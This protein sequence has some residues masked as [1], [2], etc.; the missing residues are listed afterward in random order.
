MERLQLPESPKLA[1]VARKTRLLF[2]RQ[3]DSP[4]AL[5]LLSPFLS[6]S[7]CLSLWSFD[8][9]ATEHPADAASLW[10]IVNQLGQHLRTRPNLPSLMMYSSLP[11]TLPT[12]PTNLSI[13]SPQHM[14]SSSEWHRVWNLSSNAPSTMHKDSLSFCSGVHMGTPKGM[15]PLKPSWL[16]SPTIFCW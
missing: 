11:A 12:F 3:T 10:A 7:L 9:L 1:I 4:F 13:A 15:P 14:C 16:G 2:Q 6:T 5:L 8:L